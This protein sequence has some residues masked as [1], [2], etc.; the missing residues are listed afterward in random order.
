MIAAPPKILPLSE[1]F[2]PATQ[3]DLAETVRTAYDGKTPVYPLGGGTAL[4]YGLVGKTPGWGLNTKALNKVVDY[5]A[6]DM[7]ITVESGV[8]ISELQKVLSAEGQH[9][10][11]DIA[12]P[13]EATLGGAISVN[14]SGP[15]R[16]GHGTLRDYVIGISAVDGRGKEFHAG[17]RVVKNVAGY[18]FCKLLVGSLG[19]LAVVT[20]VTLKVKPIPTSVTWLSFTAATL[21]QAESALATIAASRATPIAVELLSGGDMASWTDGDGQSFDDA[22]ARILV[23][24]EGTVSETAWM[25][26]SLRNELLIAGLRHDREMTDADACSKLLERLTAFGCES[27][28]STKPPLVLKFNIRP[29]GVVELVAEVRRLLPDATLLAHA[30]AG[31]VIVRSKPEVTI[32]DIAKSLLA[33]CSRSRHGSGGNASSGIRPLRKS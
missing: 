16:F 25:S 21:E 8:T 12:Q 26:A 13:Q 5:P 24:V 3:A 18:D 14:M 31:I 20:Q 9:L 22:A 19:T 1:T 15:R 4:A 29:S 27:A 32:H 6:R 23:G 11:V 28:T 2:T 17:G 30:A 7:T 10:P 33:L